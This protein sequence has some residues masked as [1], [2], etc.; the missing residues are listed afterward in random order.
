MRSTIIMKKSA[1]IAMAAMITVGF[2]MPGLSLISGTGSYA[3]A[4]VNT[5]GETVKA[6]SN[7]TITTTD[8]QQEAYDSGM[9]FV[10][11]GTECTFAEAQ[12]ALKA[13]KSVSVFDQY[14]KPYKTTTGEGKDAVTKS[15]LFASNT[16]KVGTS[17]YRIG[18]YITN[19]GVDGDLT[20]VSENSSLTGSKLSLG[21]AVVG[22][23]T[24]TSEDGQTTTV[25]G[26]KINSTSDNLNGIVVN[27]ADSAKTTTA[28][29]NDATINM[30]GKS[31]G[32][33][34][35]CDFSSWGAAIGIFGNAKA[36]I[37]NA[38]IHTTGVARCAIE[39]DSGAD[40]L[41]KNSTIKVDGGTLYSGYQNT[42]DTEVMVAPPWVLGI[43][44]NA[45][46][47][48]LLGNY[49]TATYLNTTTYAAKWGVLSTDGCSNVVLNAINSK[50]NMDL[51]GDDLTED[52]GY[53]TYAIGSATE[54]FL[55]TTFN[56]PTYAVICANGENKVTFASSKGNIQTKK[57]SDSTKSYVNGAYSFKDS[58]IKD[59][60]TVVNSENFGVD[61]WGGGTVNVLD[62]TTFNTGNAA[63]LIKSGG[64]FTGA[65]VNINSSKINS[66]NNVIMQVIDNED[67]AA[68]G[69][70]FSAG[71]PNFSKAVYNETK[72]WLGVGSNKTLYK[73][74][75]KD[76][77]STETLNITNAKLTGNIF[78]GS[79]YKLMGSTLNVTLGKN[80]NLKGKIS[81]TTIKHTTDGG[82][83]QNTTISQDKYYQFGHVINKAHYN[84]TNKVSVTLTG[85]SV[86]NVTGK[87][88]VTSLKVGSNAKVNGKVYVNG[89]LTNIKAGKTYTGTIVVYAK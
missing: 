23:K 52:S 10:S 5:G 60:K 3:Y 69:A 21:S 70:D 12:A 9:T 31:D 55:G 57:Y 54:N 39:V 62:G 82:K 30:L 79:G 89:K 58:E 78:N 34:T 25:D 84:G 17:K 71:A 67:A 6:I 86:W 68:T 15:N 48:N 83:T 87:S 77:A 45:R 65:A 44:G 11:E 59:Q 38:N 37:N 74:T 19:G 80:A 32:N 28:Y 61:I 88:V 7:T 47:T 56:V 40:A 36:T 24:T 27:G 4:A 8:G 2:G 42:A 29:V 73:A 13:G 16:N 72:G 41:V 46:A 63:F 64:Q 26:L 35:S 85:N 18:Y 75:A 53:G 50:V 20:K 76:K 1:V 81:A 51:S 43:T 33:G 49:S 66:K 14:F 22:G